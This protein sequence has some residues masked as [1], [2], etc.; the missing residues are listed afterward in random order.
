MSALEAAGVVLLALMALA[1]VTLAVLM[2]VILWRW[3]DRW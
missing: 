1:V 3:R 2:L